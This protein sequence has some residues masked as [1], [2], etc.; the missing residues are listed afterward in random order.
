MFHKGSFCQSS[1]TLNIQVNV[2]LWDSFIEHLLFACFWQHPL[3]VLQCLQSSTADAKDWAD[4]NT[5]QI[6][7]V[8]R[9]ILNAVRVQRA[10]IMLKSWSCVQPNQPTNANSLRIAFL[11][12]LRSH[13][14]SSRSHYSSGREEAM[15]VNWLLLPRHSVVTIPSLRMGR[16]EDTDAPSHSWKW[17]IVWTETKSDLRVR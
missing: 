1:L 16:K 10:S 11:G 15:A 17:D 3:G 4:Y 5:G 14:I 8:K 2:V 6:Q 7:S 12:E 9:C 13:W